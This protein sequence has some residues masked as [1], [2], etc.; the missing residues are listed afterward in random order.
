MTVVVAFQW[1]LEP[2]VV[3]LNLRG[4]RTSRADV[5]AVIAPIFPSS[6]IHAELVADLR[7]L[8]GI[9]ESAGPGR[10]RLPIAA[11]GESC[12]SLTFV[13]RKTPLSF[14]LE[15]GGLR[16]QVV[17]GLDFLALFTESRLTFEGNTARLTMERR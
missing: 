5:A 15:R 3:V 17:L 11:Q 12:G 6:W 4:L 10:V 14:R 1:R 8:G 7:I 13:Q 2:A 16:A 9:V